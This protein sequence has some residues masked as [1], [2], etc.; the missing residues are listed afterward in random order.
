MHF[1]IWKIPE[2]EIVLEKYFLNNELL[3]F[4][5]KI[6]VYLQTFAFVMDYQHCQNLWSKKTK[7]PSD[8][9]SVK[10]LLLLLLSLFESQKHLFQF[11]YLKILFSDQLRFS[12]VI[13]ISKCLYLS[14]ENFLWELLFIAMTVIGPNI[15]TEEC[16]SCSLALTPMYINMYPLKCPWHLVLLWPFTIVQL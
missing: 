11:P 12:N 3:Y 9:A 2:Y 13:S 5:S 4:L 15:S 6:K 14:F 8:V 1:Y 16:K 7:Q 10:M